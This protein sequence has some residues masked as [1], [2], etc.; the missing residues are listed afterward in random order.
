MKEKAAN[1]SFP[2]NNQIREVRP[3]N[4]KF[5]KCSQSDWSNPTQKWAK[6]LQC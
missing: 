2:R 3:V 5:E 4:E 1:A 6:G